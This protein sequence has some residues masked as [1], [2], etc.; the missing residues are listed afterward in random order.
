M[1]KQSVTLRLNDD[2][3]LRI[4]QLAETFN[5]SQASIVE[6]AV[7]NFVH[8]F[9]IAMREQDGRDSPEANVALMTTRFAQEQQRAFDE[10]Q[11]AY[12]N[13]ESTLMSLIEKFN[14]RANI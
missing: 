13:L 6:I 4:Q 2:T 1:T 8:Q 9:A 5:K 14:N 3:R 10:Y 7:G 12:E 11:R